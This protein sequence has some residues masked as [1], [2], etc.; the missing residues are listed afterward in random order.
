MP[1]LVLRYWLSVLIFTREILW[2]WKVCVLKIRTHVIFPLSRVFWRLQMRH[3]RIFG[4][5]ILCWNGFSK[6]LGFA[7]CQI[8]TSFFFF[9]EKNSVKL[10]LALVRTSSPF[11]YASLF[12]IVLRLAM[13]HS[14]IFSLEI[15]KY[16][17]HVFKWLLFEP[18]FK[19]LHV[20]FPGNIYF[21]DVYSAW[22]GDS[23][24]NHFLHVRLACSSN[25]PLSSFRSRNPKLSLMVLWEMSVF[26]VR[27]LCRIQEHAIWPS[28]RATPCACRCSALAFSVSIS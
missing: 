15:L 10:E 5:A 7:F 18:C 16:S 20:R 27:K 14:G 17:S 4:L 6:T 9:N 1:V 28:S 26:A 3:S 19:S 22:I 24:P 2:N 11:H 13:F 12:K 21:N 23:H 8:F 25:V